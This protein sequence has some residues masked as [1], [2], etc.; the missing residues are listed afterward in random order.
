[1]GERTS[2]QWVNDKTVPTKPCSARR[3]NPNVCGHV[4]PPRQIATLLRK[5]N[6]FLTYIECEAHALSN[7]KSGE[8]TNPDTQYVKDFNEKVKVIHFL[9]WRGPRYEG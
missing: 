8:V 5:W 1:M 9:P 4:G 7:H 6:L 3:D 2:F